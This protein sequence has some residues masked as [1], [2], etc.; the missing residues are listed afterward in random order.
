MRHQR[1]GKKL[2][3]DSAHR[4]ALYANLA[5]DL[6]E[7]ERIKT[8]LTKAKAVKPIAE[9]MITL[10][11]RGDIHARRQAVAF[12]GSKDIVHK[13][14]DEL[15]PR[16]AERPGGYTRIVRLG[17]RLG[18]A[19][20]VVYLELVDTPLVFKTKLEDVKG[21]VPGLDTGVEEGDEPEAEAEGAE[22]EAEAAVEGEPAAEEAAAAE[23]SDAEAETAEPEAVEP[24]AVEPEAVEPEAE[25]G[26]DA[27]P[28]AD[29]ESKDA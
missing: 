27:E 5:S 24:E 29:A 17:P 13:L 10:G 18:D 19:A 8:T 11:R 22:P 2:G 3:R 12:L 23:E 26:A 15:G 4:R 20:E 21:P 16:Y 28:E 14:F 9:Q 25:A 1:S 6:I 7:H